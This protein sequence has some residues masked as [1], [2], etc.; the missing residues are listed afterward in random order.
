M[1]EWKQGVALAIAMGITVE[2]QCSIPKQA[3][4]LYS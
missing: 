3:V 1:K 2:I 4:N